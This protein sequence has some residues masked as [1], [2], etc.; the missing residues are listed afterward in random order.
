MKPSR[1]GR[2][3]NETDGTRHKEITVVVPRALRALG[4]TT[5][6]SLRRG[7]QFHFFP[8]ELDGFI[9]LATLTHET[10]ASFIF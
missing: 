8:T 10:T 2:E 9:I 4:T 1:F 7:R 5:V 3:K 6:I